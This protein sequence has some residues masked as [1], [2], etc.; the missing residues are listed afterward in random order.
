MVRGVIFDVGGTIIW[1]N[2]KR[3]IKANAWTATNYLRS[4]GFK[5]D[6]K[7]FAERLELLQKDSAKSDHKLRQINTTR[8][9]LR[10]LAG[11]YGIDL[12]KE[13]LDDVERSY[14]SPEV[15]GAIALPGIVHVLEKLKGRVAIA[16]LSNTRS[17]ALIAEILKKLQLDMFDI[18]ATSPSVGHRKPSPNIFKPIID[19]WGFAAKEIVMI[20][21]LPHKDIAG[22]KQLGLK[23]I[24]LTIDSAADDDYGADAVAKEPLEILDILNNWGLPSS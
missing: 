1:K 6:Y 16:V 24:W 7:S 12:S 10:M 2:G 22:A 13:L 9:H 17:H 20:G 8:E 15:A 4:Q 21:D 3:Y 19:I 14:I 5:F 18:V 11:D 23:S